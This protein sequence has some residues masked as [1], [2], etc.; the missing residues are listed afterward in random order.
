MLRCF[1]LS[2]VLL[3]SNHLQAAETV[4]LPRILVFGDSLSAAYGIPREQGWVAL[5]EQR[6]QAENYPYQVVNVSVSGETTHGGL[7]RLP[8]A[9]SRYKPAIVI[10]ELGANDGLR[11]LSLKAMQANLEQMLQLI[12]EQHAQAILLGM[13]IPSNYGPLYTQAFAKIYQTLAEQQ[14]IPLLN[15][16]FSGL[17]E[18]GKLRAELFQ[19]D[20]LHPNV[21][22]QSLLLESI[23]P[24]LQPLLKKS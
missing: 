12:R 2:L 4:N 19:E 9:L 22:A 13:R 20:G 14:Q 11:G 15:F 5:L 17:A 23:W 10:L 6:L 24:V 18:N 7:T 1:L 16:L 21:Q 3:F 8:A